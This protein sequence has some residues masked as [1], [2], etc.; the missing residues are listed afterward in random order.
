[1]LSFFKI[2]SL[3][4]QVFFLYNGLA[5]AGLRLSVFLIGVL[6]VGIYH[7]AY[8]SE[9]VKAGITSIPVGQVEAAK[10]QVLPM[11]NTCAISSCHKLSKLFSHR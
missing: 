11:F 1:M 3:V 9:V 8:V 2:P 5:I 4:I 7:G 6:G 10:S